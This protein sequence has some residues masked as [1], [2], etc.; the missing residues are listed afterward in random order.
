MTWRGGVRATVVMLALAL[1]LFL[2][3]AV[4]PEPESFGVRVETYTNFE[5]GQTHPIA[6]DP[7]GTRLFVVNTADARLSVFDVTTPAAPRLLREIPVGIDPVSVRPRSDDEAWV[8]NQVSD[9]VSIVSV[10]RGIVTDTLQAKDEP[11]D[12]VFV[13]HRAFVTVARSNAVRVFDVTTH[14]PIASIPLEGEHPRAIATSVDGR[15]VYVAFALSGNRTTIISPGVAPPPPDPTNPSLPLAPRQGLIV[16]SADPSWRHVVPYTVADHDVAEIDTSTLAVS[17]Y[18]T[19]VGTINMGLAVHPTTG[20]LFIANTDARNLVRFE[21]NLRGH[22]VDNRVTRV[23]VADGRAVPFDL[24]PTVDYATLPNPAARAIALAQPTALVFKSDGSRFY[25]AAFGTDRVARLDVHGNVLDRI[26]VG[27]VTAAGGT[28]D[29]RHKRGPRGLALHPRAPYLYV[30]NRVS[31][32]LA[33]IETAA[34]PPIL[35]TEITVGTFDPTPAVIRHG[36]GFLYDAKLSGNGTAACAACHV[37]ADVDLLA[38]DLG[39]PGGAMQ[40]VPA[41]PVALLHPMKGPMMTQT[42]RGLARLE[43]LHWRGDRP[44]F[45]AFNHAFDTLLGGTDLSGPDMTT[46]RDFVETLRF[47]PNPNQHLDRTLPR[48]V[49]GGDPHVGREVFLTQKFPFLV[50]NPD[51]KVRCATCHTV[52]PPG[53]GRGIFEARSLQL[54]QAFKVPQL[55]SFYQRR[56]FQTQPGSTSVNG[57]GFSADGSFASVFD[58]LSR[59]FFGDIATDPYAQAHLN[60]FLLTFDTGTAPAVGYTRTIG[61]TRVGDDE[62]AADWRVLEGQAA[63]GHIDLIAKGTI[64]GKIRGLLYRPGLDDYVT[65][66]TGVGPFTQAQLWNKIAAGDILTVMGVPPGSGPRMGI[67]RNLDGRFDGD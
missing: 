46:F 64:D 62:I 63:V 22:P 40:T 5:G 34:T 41:A 17:R 1:G 19:G 23:T 36:R 65:D 4:H 49:A 13:G 12:L 9:S 31:N 16:D 25:V 67:D 26:E 28:A 11:A 3:K 61:P 56:G 29:P 57:F 47:A 32:T 42:L 66:R 48:S 39:D 18:F 52:Y 51:F 60:A 30:L 53:T 37:D 14:A 45:L 8:V 2:A 6:L 55:R 10:S 38:W 27:P 59:P 58:F 21:P 20:D 44:S 33:V 35:L 15:H 7:S 24:N 50:G 54:P 43:P